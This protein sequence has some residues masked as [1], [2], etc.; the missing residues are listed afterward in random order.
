MDLSTDLPSTVV[1]LL[2]DLPS[3]AMDLSTDSTVTTVMD[4]PSDSA[5][6]RPDRDN[7]MNQSEKNP[8]VTIV[9]SVCGGITGILIIVILC[10]CIVCI[11]KHIQVHVHYDGEKNSDNRHQEN[12]TNSS[13][14]PLQM[15]T[16]YRQAV[17]TSNIATTIPSNG[18]SMQCNL[19][20]GGL[21]N[22]M[23]KPG[24][25]EPG[26]PGDYEKMSG[27]IAFRHG[28]PTRT[29]EEG[30][31]SQLALPMEYI[32]PVQ[33]QGPSNTYTGEYY[34]DVHCYEYIR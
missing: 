34:D 24:I 7:N 27:Y 1:D 25:V 22:Q 18:N 30:T 11:T 17:P 21:Q 28:N 16:T 3:T 4:L 26:S 6:T 2:T 9:A 19:A 14:T 13:D 33:Q 31:Y 12:T 10:I 23:H 20:Y 8:T 32:M 5:R 15:N 29:E